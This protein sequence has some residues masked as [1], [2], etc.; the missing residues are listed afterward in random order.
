ME[1]KPKGNTIINFNSLQVLSFP[2]KTWYCKEYSRYS[3]CHIYFEDY[4]KWNRGYT[5]YKF[6]NELLYPGSCLYTGDTS[7][8]VDM[9]WTKLMR[10]ID[11]ILI[12]EN[13][14]KRKL[15]LYQ[16]PHHGS[17]NSN[18]ERPINEGRIHAAFTNYGDFWGK[19]IFNYNFA[20]DYEIKRKPLILVTEKELTQFEEHW[21]INE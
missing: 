16:I 10:M 7:A 15:V 13:K 14:K 21:I 12:D 5:Q 8:N 1:G 18:D 3:T 20:I 17:G 9:V 2:V 19:C 4:Y 6:N 11:N